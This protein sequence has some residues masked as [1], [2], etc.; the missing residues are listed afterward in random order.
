M[1]GYSPVRGKCAFWREQPNDE[2]TWD[3]SV[4]PDDKRVTCTCFVEGDMWPATMSTIPKDCP[5]RFKCRYYVR[6]A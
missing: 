4:K 2:D 6:T 1:D 3:L 5:N